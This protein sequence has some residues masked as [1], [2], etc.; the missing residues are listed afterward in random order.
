MIDADDTV[1]NQNTN[2]YYDATSDE[3]DL[4]PIVSQITVPANMH[5]AVLL[6]CKKA[7]LM[8]IETHSIGVKHR[9]SITPWGLMDTLPGNQVHVYIANFDD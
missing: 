7:E 5:S 3:V 8:T 4:C 1:S 9:C 6:K 2:S